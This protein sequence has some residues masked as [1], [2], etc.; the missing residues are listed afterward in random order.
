MKLTLIRLLNITKIFQQI[1]S[2]IILIVGWFCVGSTAQS[3]LLVTSL[4]FLYREIAHKTLVRTQSCN[5]A[6]YLQ[7]DKK[8][9]NIANLDRSNTLNTVKIVLAL[10]WWYLLDLNYIHIKKNSILDISGG[11]YTKM[12]VLLSKLF[13]YFSF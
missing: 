10:L 12:L 1:P 11:K 3:Y 9:L 2:I 7:P 8:H 13:S 6:I 5:S 4:S